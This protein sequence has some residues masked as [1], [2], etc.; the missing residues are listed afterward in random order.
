MQRRDSFVTFARVAAR[1]KVS[2]KVWRI[3]RGPEFRACF[4]FRAFALFLARESRSL[5]R[6]TLTQ[7]KRE[8]EEK[9]LL[10]LCINHTQN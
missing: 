3:A 10:C 2:K 9:S 6:D 5:A 4:S 8:T 7:M 1:A